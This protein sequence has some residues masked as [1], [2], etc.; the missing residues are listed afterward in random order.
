MRV[1]LDTCVLSELQDPRGSAAVRNTV[2]SI[3]DGDLFI[4]VISLG[5]IAKGVAQLPESAKKRRLKGWLD[6]L[7][8]GY[9]ERALPIDR[10]VSRIWGEVTAAAQ[11]RGIT[12]GAADGLIAS[13]ALRHG[14]RVMTRNVKNFSPA[15]VRVINPFE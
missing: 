2:E 1:L 15:N 8:S 11:K 12:L 4:S 9:A 10:E 7:E 6:G 5:E 14:L 3:E 13:T